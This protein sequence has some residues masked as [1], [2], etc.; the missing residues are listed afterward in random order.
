MPKL[1]TVDS[2]IEAKQLLSFPCKHHTSINSIM[3][4]HTEEYLLSSDTVHCYLWNFEKPERPYKVADAQGDK[5]IEEVEETINFST[6]HPSSDC[7]FLF[8][9]NKGQLSLCDLR[10]SSS[11]SS[12]AST[13]KN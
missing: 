4:S 3:S 11:G 10:L 2:N 13:F 6:M 5:K 1:Q 12:A 8:G 7:M 9:T